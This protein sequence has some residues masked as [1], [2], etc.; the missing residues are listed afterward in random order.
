MRDFK[1]T[2][3]EFVKGCG[4]AAI[5]SA[6]G[7]TLMFADP[8]DAAV[9]S[10]D[11]VV[12]LFLRGGLDGLNL[13]LVGAKLGGARRRP[14][15]QRVQARVRGEEPPPQDAHPLAHLLQQHPAARSA[16]ASI[17][18]MPIRSLGLSPSTER[19][20]APVDPRFDCCFAP[21]LSVSLRWPGCAL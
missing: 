20:G 7:G 14:R 15:D 3:R 8:V 9:N 21:A 17:Q 18:G 4:S 16:K 2:R 13:Q 5:V 6:T 1:L 10:Y 19:D 12:H 11:T